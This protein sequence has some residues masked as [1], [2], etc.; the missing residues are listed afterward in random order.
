MELEFDR[1]TD[2]A[3]FEILNKMRIVTREI[4]PGVMGDY[5]TDGRLI[6]VEVLAISK[7][8]SSV[9]LWRTA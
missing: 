8:R 2:A 4:K 6:G 9:L 7:H 5:D 3:Y 1:V